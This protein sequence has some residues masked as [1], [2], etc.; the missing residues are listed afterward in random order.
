MSQVTDEID[1]RAAVWAARVAGG[2]LTPDEEAC[3]EAW[4]AA[5]IR[6]IGAFAR[7]QAILLRL[8][9]LRA[10]GA[11]ALRASIPEM[12]ATLADTSAATLSVAAPETP[13]SAGQL[14]DKSGAAVHD[15]PPASTGSPKWTRRRIMLNGSAA[16]SVAAAGIVGAAMIW[17]DRSRTSVAAPPVEYFSTRMGETRSARLVDGS[18]VTLNTNS[19]ISVSYTESARNI[20]LDQ[21]EALF[22]VAKNKKRPFIVTASDT[23]VRAVG[24]SFTVRFLPQRPVQILVQEGVVEVAHKG[25]RGS[26]PI[27]ATAETQAVV[28]ANAPI[29]VRAV[30]HPQVERNLA[31]QFGRIAFENETL[32]DAAVEFARYSE[33]KIT[34]DPAVAKRTI[35]G[36][37]ASNDPVGFA[38]AA[39]SVLDLH[40]EVESKEVW[41]VR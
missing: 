2:D 33:T 11:G 39:A 36:L 16:A 14:T 40:V 25:V 20:R 21:G 1:E 8:D 12:P 38:K 18:V 23:V 22:N 9:R 10:V 35:T 15:M 34:V 28:A 26:R 13:S 31:W 7:A 30:P 29:V 32:A 24:T 3:F 19:K 17:N 27:R 4:R 41:I 6:H 5:D 37:F